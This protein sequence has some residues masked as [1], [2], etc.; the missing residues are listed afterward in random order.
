MNHEYVLL[1]DK[2]WTQNAQWKSQL[3]K[4]TYFDSIYMRC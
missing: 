4:S 2:P 1:M 3:Q